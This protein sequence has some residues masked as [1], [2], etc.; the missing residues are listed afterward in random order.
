MSSTY[1]QQKNQ[2]KKR[3][4]KW[5]RIIHK[6]GHSDN[7]LDALYEEGD[8][9]HGVGFRAFMDS[10]IVHRVNS[11]SKKNLSLTQGRYDILETDTTPK[12]MSFAEIQKQQASGIL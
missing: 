9:R 3:E 7:A 1:K 4:V 6:W 11:S 2:A 8:D 10:I 12:I 5:T